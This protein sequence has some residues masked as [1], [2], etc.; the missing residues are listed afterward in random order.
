MF[1]VLKCYN[2]VDI[3]HWNHFRNFLLL[4]WF[5]ILQKHV[6]DNLSHVYIQQ[7]SKYK[8]KTDLIHAICVKTYNELN[9]YYNASGIHLSVAKAGVN[10]KTRNL[11]MTS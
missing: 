7:V 3:I 4:L 9:T 1:W 2:G 6:L 8:P 10:N 11:M 5:L